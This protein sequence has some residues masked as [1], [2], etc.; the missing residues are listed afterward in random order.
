ML[1]RLGHHFF[2]RR[3]PLS[4]VVLIMVVVVTGWMASRRPSSDPLQRIADA[5]GLALVGVSLAFRALVV[6]GS[7]P[8]TSGRN[9]DR[10]I[11]STLNTT[12]AYSVVRHPLYL[13]NLV[14]WVG[15]AVISAVWWLPLAMLAVGLALYGPILVVEDAFLEH[16]FGAEHRRW[17]EQ[18]PALVPRFSHWR[19]TSRS[20][21]WRAVL[22]R[23]YPSLVV[24]AIAAYLVHLA[25]TLQAWRSD[26]ID[27]R[28]TG[29]LLLALGLATILRI[30]SHTTTLLDPG[31]PS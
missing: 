16:R 8:G 27:W 2:R 11:A 1:E 29:G 3:G 19:P 9:Q 25:R 26:G 31:D 15:I 13:A 28:W 21:S 5:T 17:A 7:A 18:T 10:Q 23:E 6:G 4:G 22:R 20:F 30:V 24:T 14:A 12:G